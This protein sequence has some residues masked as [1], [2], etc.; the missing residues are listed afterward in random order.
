MIIAHELY[1]ICILSILFIFNP[2]WDQQPEKG[3]KER[4]GR[5]SIKKPS[6][7][8]GKKMAIFRKKRIQMNTTNP[9]GGSSCPSQSLRS[10]TLTHCSFTQSIQCVLDHSTRFLTQYAAIRNQ[11]RRREE[12]KASPSRNGQPATRAP[13]QSTA[14]KGKKERTMAAPFTHRPLHSTRAATL[15][16]FHRKEPP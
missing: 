15:T 10:L 14:K 4:G 8:S 7:I 16:M 3:G 5:H 12:N 11:A 2:D 1:K 9:E 13:R 6:Y